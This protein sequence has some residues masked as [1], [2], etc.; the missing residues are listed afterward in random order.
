M[1]IESETGKKEKKGEK[2]TRIILP[3]SGIKFGTIV[4]VAFSIL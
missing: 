4:F 1:R 3:H 2:K